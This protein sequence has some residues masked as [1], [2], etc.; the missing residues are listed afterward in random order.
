[1]R[2]PG[3]FVRQELATNAFDHIATPKARGA[4]TYEERTSART[5]WTFAASSDGPLTIDRSL[6]LAGEAAPH[7]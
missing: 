2:R 3:G 5:S 4:F 1:V 6:P 7:E